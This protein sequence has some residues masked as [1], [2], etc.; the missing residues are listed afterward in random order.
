MRP[1]G[2]TGTAAAPPPPPSYP[3]HVSPPQGYE[4]QCPNHSPMGELPAPPWPEVPPAPTATYSRCR[5]M[6]SKGLSPRDDTCWKK[7]LIRS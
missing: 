2:R 5:A 3:D 7:P 4:K 1:E 6:S